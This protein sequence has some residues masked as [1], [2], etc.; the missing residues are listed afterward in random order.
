MPHSLARLSTSASLHRNLSSAVFITNI[1][2]SDFRYRQ[3][4]AIQAITRF[5]RPTN[6]LGLPSLVVPAGQSKSGL[7]IG[8]QLI[9]RP[10]GDETLIALGL[11]FQAATNHHRR[12]PAL[13]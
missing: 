4:A 13:P 9:G 5:M 1:A 10:F 3:E 2:E 12:V 6:F 11:A 7:P 8:M